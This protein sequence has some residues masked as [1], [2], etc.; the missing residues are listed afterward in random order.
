MNIGIDIDDTINNMHDIILKKGIEFNKREKIDFKINPNLWDLKKAFGWDEFTVEKFLDETLE[1]ACFKAETKENAVEVINK[2]QR[3]GN[4]IIIITSRTT[5]NAYEISEKWLKQKNV[6][7]D[8]LIVGS[9]DKGKTCLENEIDV[10]I[11]DNV[12]FCNSV[13]ATN[14]KVL[15]FDSPCNQKEMNFKRVY[16]W[17]EVY[18]EIKK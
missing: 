6:N 17:D 13:S 14:A 5:K 16:S 4:K 10:F 18:K 1:E 8:K 2:L 7:Y 12:E 15:M 11:D 9:T 3:E